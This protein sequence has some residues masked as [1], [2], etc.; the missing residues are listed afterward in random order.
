MSNF[1]TNIGA[2]F[3]SLLNWLGQI[4]SYLIT[5]PIFI[6]I[7]AIGIFSVLYYTIKKISY[8]IK[9]K[10]SWKENYANTLQMEEDEYNSIEDR[11]RW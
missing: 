9:D 4:T 8:N 10:K 3:E 2:V 5:N 6:I 7:M 1:L 11:G